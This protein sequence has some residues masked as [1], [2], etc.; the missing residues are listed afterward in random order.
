MPNNLNRLNSLIETARSQGILTSNLFSVNER[1]AMQ[2]KASRVSSVP[3]R[4]FRNRSGDAHSDA[5]G[6]VS[7]SNSFM[8]DLSYTKESANH[9]LHIKFVLPTNEYFPPPSLV[10]PSVMR[11]SRDQQFFRNELVSFGLGGLAGAGALNLREVRATIGTWGKLE[12][13]WAHRALE[14]R[15]R[16]RGPAP[17]M[18]RPMDSTP[19]S[20]VNTFLEELPFEEED[21][22]GLCD[23]LDMDA[24]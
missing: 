7:L 21:P 8:Q 3:V 2:D 24:P 10:L 16:E 18:P 12:P 5:A 17:I 4:S 11:A 9:Q 19:M 20:P 1:H 14:E 23:D 22:F 13:S 15:E 6:L